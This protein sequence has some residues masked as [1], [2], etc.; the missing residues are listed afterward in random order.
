MIK[1]ELVT[2]LRAALE[3]DPDV[4]LHRYPIEIRFDGT[5]HLAG[6]VEHIAAKRKIM[7][8]ARRLANSGRIEDQL[9]IVVGERRTDDAL[10][11]GV[12]RA[13]TEEPA[14]HGLSIG[15]PDMDHPA[16]SDWITVSAVGATVHLE[17]RVNSLSHRRLAEVL[18]WWVP[19]TARVENRL[20]V[21]PPEEDNDDEITDAV[22]II[23]EKDPSLDGEEIRART[24]E[25]TVTLEGT[26]RTRENSRIAWYDCWYIPGVHQ[27]DNR[28][29]VRQT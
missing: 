1:N 28:L 11:Q 24:R 29:Q 21:Y 26:V 12:L 27:V 13:L 25:R 3:R 10:R 16:E 23:L 15:G 9:D 20:R 5:L 2:S 6:E 17:G 18:A 14:F 19:G 22:R 4:N 7:Q 8:I